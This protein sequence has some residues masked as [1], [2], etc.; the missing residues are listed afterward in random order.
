M[1]GDRTQIVKDSKSGCYLIIIAHYQVRRNSILVELLMVLNSR[2][3][4]V[5]LTSVPI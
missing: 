2:Q 5:Q 3:E 1:L 4:C